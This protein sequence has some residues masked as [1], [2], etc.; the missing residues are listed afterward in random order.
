MRISELEQEGASLR[1]EKESVELKLAGA[2]QESRSAHVEDAGKLQ[3]QLEE[4]RSKLAAAE[5]LVHAQELQIEKLKSEAAKAQEKAD[6]ISVKQ[7]DC[8]QSTEFQIQQAENQLLKQSNQE[9]EQQIVQLETDK[10]IQ[11][12]TIDQLKAQ[13]A[14]ASTSQ[15]EDLKQR[16]AS[17]ESAQDELQQ[18]Y[19]E[20]AKK[21]QDTA[22]EAEER[23][24]RLRAEEA[25]SQKLTAAVSELEDQLKRKSEELDSALQTCQSTQQL[26]V[27]ARASADTSSQLIEQMKQQVTELSQAN[28]KL[29]SDKKCVSADLSG[30]TSGLAKEADEMKKLL[31]AKESEIETVNQ[32]IEIF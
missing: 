14:S 31:L 11:S 26:Y 13:L 3:R 27:N 1:S 9:L 12:D 28:A 24:E 10:K 29:L 17:L 30:A 22:A 8:Q 20:A 32:K 5:E 4:I 19:A 18:N 6:S 23:I 16:V 21:L 25:R 15:S 2:L 7:P